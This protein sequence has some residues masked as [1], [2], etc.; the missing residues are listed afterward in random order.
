MTRTIETNKETKS[1][2]LLPSTDIKFK[3][4]FT[5]GKRAL[6]QFILSSGNSDKIASPHKGKK[7]NDDNG[8]NGYIYIAFIYPKDI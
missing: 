3:N 6:F 4:C 8:T 1:F 7:K 2:R 5:S